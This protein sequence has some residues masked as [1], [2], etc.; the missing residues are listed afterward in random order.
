MKDGISGRK[1]LGRGGISLQWVRAENEPMAT[2]VIDS[3]TVGTL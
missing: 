1:I 2:Q 3:K